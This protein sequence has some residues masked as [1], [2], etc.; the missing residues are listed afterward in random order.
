MVAR[1]AYL[2][3]GKGTFGQINVVAKLAEAP[4]QW[5]K[6]GAGAMG[7]E[8]RPAGRAGSVRE[9]RPLKGGH[10]R[11]ASVTTAVW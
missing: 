9:M 10:D 1:G 5:R 6:E 7:E 8:S 3:G 4:T 11:P 2:L